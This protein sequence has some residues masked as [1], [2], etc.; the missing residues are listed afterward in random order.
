MWDISDAEVVCQQLG[1]GHALDAIRSPGFGPGKGKIL[2]DDVSCVGNER[3][4]INCIQNNWGENN[5]NHHEDAGVRCSGTRSIGASGQCLQNCGLGYYLQGNILCTACDSNCLD[6][7]LAPSKCEQCKPTTFLKSDT[8][9]CTID[10]G[11]GM[12]GN[13]KTGTCDRCD[14]SQCRTCA[15]GPLNNNCTSCP[16]TKV[17]K[18]STCV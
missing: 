3:E 5:C 1:Y 9:T 6:C 7:S 11:I 13:V 14:L 2:L 16:D 15:D 10:C 18:G 17:L 8:H 4:I 12:F